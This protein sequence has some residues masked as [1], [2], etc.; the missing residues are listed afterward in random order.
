MSVVNGQLANQTTFNNAFMSRTAPTT[1]TVAKVALQDPDF[2]NSGALI[3]NLQKAINKAFQGTGIA[4]ENDTAVNDYANNNYI[5]DGDSR[6]VAIEKLDAELKLVDDLAQDVDSRV[7]DL[8]SNNMTINGQKTFSGKTFFAQE[9]TMDILG[10]TPTTPVAGKKAIYPK[11]DG[12]YSL[13][14]NGIEKKVG[15]GSGGGGSLKWVEDGVT[16]T[17]A[18]EFGQQ[19]YLFEN[20]GVQKLF[21]LIKVP[22]GYTP[23][24]PISLLMPFYSPDNSGDV[25][26]QTVTTLIKPGTDPIN[27]T[28]N[29]HTSTNTAFTLTTANVPESFDLDLTDTSGEINGVAVDAGDLLKVE[30]S[31]SVDTATSEVRAL[32]YGSEMTLE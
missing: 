9:I 29:Q 3:S 5:L 1:S 24:S 21:A 7:T 14:E 18:T 31:R 8:E 13:D 16:P 10:A 30:L 28:T 17:P 11:A 20:G 27:D 19:V 32:V 2:S 23:G 6:K 25:L 26:L 15:S 12:F 4:D 22:A